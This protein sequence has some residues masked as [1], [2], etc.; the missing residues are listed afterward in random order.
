MPIGTTTITWTVT[1]VKGNTADCSFDVQVNAYVDGIDTISENGIL[2]YPN[3]ATNQ[4]T[5][6]YEDV[7]IKNIVILDITGKAISNMTVR[8]AE[9]PQI[10][11]VSNLTKGVYFIKLT[12]NNMSKFVRFIKN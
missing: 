11:D 8:K 1:D 10:I 5:I 9:Q 12:T 4:L 3:P 6:E 2:I 7:K